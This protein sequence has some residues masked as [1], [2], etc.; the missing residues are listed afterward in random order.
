M[1]ITAD[2]LLKESKTFCILPWVHLYVTPQGVTAPCCISKFTNSSIGV[3][4]SQR[5]SVAEIMNGETMTKLRVDM[6]KGV[7]HTSCE[8]C[9]QYE[10]QGIESPRASFN[11]ENS[12]H[13]TADLI[14][15]DGSLL[16]FKL[17]YFDIRF[18]NICNFKCRTCGSNCSSLWEQEDKKHLGIIQIKND[19]RI[20]LDEVIGQI[21]NMDRAYFAG[22]EPLITDEHYLLLEEMIKQKRTDIQLM[23]NTNLSNIRFKDKDLLGLWKHFT[24]NVIVYASIDHY[25]ERAEY[26]RHGTDW[27]Q[28]ENN[29]DTIRRTS[30]IDIQMNTVL[31][32]YNCSSMLEF[33][34]Y[35]ID[36]KL[37][38]RTDGS[39]N[40]YNL[41]TPEFLSAN[42]LPDRYKI[43]ARANL[44]ELTKV[45][46]VAFHENN[47]KL[48]PVTNSI[49]WL[50]ADSTWDQYKEQF[51]A[52]T[53]RI[54]QI[55]GEDFNRTFPELAG[56]LDE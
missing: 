20:I 1:N 9:H 28:V 50:A 46:K 33:Y 3:G 56:L 15:P 23:Y 25:G 13:V 39:N 31:S 37:Y 34:K 49:A 40:I 52:E 30:N 35:L 41:A 6:L 24:H 44:Q 54:D 53:L 10:E 12:R 18:S 42:I 22:G 32:V 17:R 8:T 4:D 47:N 27:A 51:K 38:T 45:M 26:I 21:Q 36:K 5:Y 16:D 2:Y 11:K 7:K 48:D 55:R 19:N 43:K 29:F 14:K